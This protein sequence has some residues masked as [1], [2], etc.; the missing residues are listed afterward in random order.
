MLIE[1]YSLVPSSL[2]CSISNV[3]RLQ[4]TRGRPHS[5]I[6]DTGSTKNTQKT[7]LSDYFTRQEREEVRAG[8][9]SLHADSG[10]CGLG[11]APLALD[12][13]RRPYRSST[14]SYRV[15]N[16]VRNTHTHTPQS[17]DTDRI[18][19]NWNSSLMIT[20]RMNIAS[21]T[22]FVLLYPDNLN[23]IGSGGNTGQY[24]C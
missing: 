18:P 20:A 23:Q 19:P 13:P 21:Q 1:S 4:F 11:T 10:G 3:L 5:P 2:V 16:V 15:R 17:E 8:M 7:L 22:H 14:S 6:P 12:R 9:R 24:V